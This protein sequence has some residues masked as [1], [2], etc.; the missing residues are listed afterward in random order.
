M[1][2]LESPLDN[3]LEEAERLSARADAAGIPMRLF[4][5][6]AVGLRSPSAQ[7]DGL[8]REY[9]DIDLAAP[10][11]ERKRVE[12]LL[13]SSGYEADRRFNALHGHQRLIFHD[14]ARGR[15]VDVFLD[16]LR[17]CHMIDFNSRLGSDRQT[18]PLAELLL[19]KLQIV[20]ANR[21]DLI[22]IVA[23]LG[24]HELSDTDGENINVLRVLEL[25]RDDWGLF[26]TSELSLAKAR[27]FAAHLKADLPY[28]V[29]E[30]V[31]LLV[32]RMRQEPK[33]TRWKLRAR[34]GE[35]LPW[36]ELPEEV[37]D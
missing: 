35:R 1:E 4:G 16:R 27:D 7:Q 17:M 11:K 25:T 26:H 24:D 6:A 3:V 22:D 19:F 23:L 15:Q 13:E 5:G 34:V 2:A 36:Y 12:Q 28:E 21:K 32:G 29:V 9:K 14:P 37:R 18:L 33:T 10:S 31:D 30:Q 20:E 8:R